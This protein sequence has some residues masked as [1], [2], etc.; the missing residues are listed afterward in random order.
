MSAKTIVVL[1]T[2]DTKGREAE[3]LRQQISAYGHTALIV[4]TGVVGTPATAAD[5][6]REE[7]A[8]AGGMPL[9]QILQHPTRDIA[10]PIMRKAPRGSSLAWQPKAECTASWPWAAPRALR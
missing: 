7:V 3:Y 6:S 4:D 5:I 8:D 9:A 2:L 1:A 10:A